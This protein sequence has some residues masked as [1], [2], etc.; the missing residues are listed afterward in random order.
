MP[1][2]AFSMFACNVEHWQVN[3]E[4]GRGGKYNIVDRANTS[5]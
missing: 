3:I 4:T 5:V 2:P 1:P